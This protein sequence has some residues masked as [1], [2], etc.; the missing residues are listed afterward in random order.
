LKDTSRWPLL[1]HPLAIAMVSSLTAIIVAVITISSQS[2][3][4]SEPDA[5]PRTQDSSQGG[6]AFRVEP[7]LAAYNPG[8]RAA[9]DRPLPAIADYPPA[10]YDYVAKLKWAKA[11]GATDV[12]ESHLRLYLQNDGA[13]RVTL[14]AI[15]AEVV[16]RSTPVN[17]TF[18]EAPSAG[19]NDLIDLS[20]DLDSGDSVAA[21]E[22]A[23]NAEAPSKGGETSFFSTK[24]VTLDPGE[25]TDIRL[26]TTTRRCLCRYRFVLEIVK[27]DSTLRLEVGDSAGRPFVISGRSPDYVDRWMDGGLACSKAGVFPADAA[28]SP[29]C[30]SPRQ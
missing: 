12:E 14:R 8:W 25:T 6:V 28:G 5:P 20:F 16:E 13:D 1:K 10:Q 26:T 30:S 22:A 17:V 15:N 19:L 3:D 4:N 21:V 18:F 29:D 9:F 24:N 2:G 7:D 23:A 27:V 11:R